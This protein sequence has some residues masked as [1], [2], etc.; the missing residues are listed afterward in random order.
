[1]SIYPPPHRRQKN[2]SVYTLRHES[3]LPHFRICRLGF[4][5]ENEIHVIKGVL[6]YISHICPSYTKGMKEL[7]IFPHSLLHTIQDVWVRVCM[8]L[9]MINIFIYSFIYLFYLFT[10]HTAHCFPLDEPSQIL[11]LHPVFVTA[12]LVT[13]VPCMM[14]TWMNAVAILTICS[15]VLNCP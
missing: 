12:I 9:L 3:H 1:M 11:P 7:C 2:W 6:K 14:W 10:I 4:L 15:N 5:G 8:L 13:Q